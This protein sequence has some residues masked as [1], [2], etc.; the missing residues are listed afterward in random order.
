MPSIP[1]PPFT[2]N[3]PS[4]P[5]DLDN[6]KSLVLVLFIVVIPV[7]DT[8]NLL[9]TFKL[10]VDIVKSPLD[11]VRPLDTVRPLYSVVAFDTDNVPSTITLPLNDIFPLTF[12]PFLMSVIALD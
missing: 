8:V 7:D 12:K 10:P 6:N 9:F 2:I 4:N 11:N 3:A 1:T 5:T